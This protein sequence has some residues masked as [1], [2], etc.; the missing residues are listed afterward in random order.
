MIDGETPRPALAGAVPEGGVQLVEHLGGRVRRRPRGLRRLGVDRRSARSLL[1][2]ESDEADLAAQLDPGR[3][4]DAGPHEFDDR[5]HI[6]R[7]A[8]VGRPG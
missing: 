8:A 5:A 4:G 3:L 6:V 7:R 1:V 2:L